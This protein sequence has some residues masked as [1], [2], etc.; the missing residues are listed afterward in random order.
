MILQIDSQ[1]SCTGRLRDCSERQRQPRCAQE[2]LH[3]RTG[4]CGS[5]DKDHTPNPWPSRPFK[6]WSPPPDSSHHPP[7]SVLWPQGME[8]N[9]ASSHLRA[10]TEAAG[11]ARTPLSTWLN[12]TSYLTTKV[13][14]SE[15]SLKPPALCRPDPPGY[16]LQRGLLCLVS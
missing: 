6:V 1:A 11:K 2:P 5:S 9:Y 3:H 10:S 7:M 4:H 8:I 16:T 14:S 13:P 15:L 12:P